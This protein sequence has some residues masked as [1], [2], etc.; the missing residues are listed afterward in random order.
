MTLLARLVALPW[1][2]K[3]AIVCAI[4]L[5]GF[6]AAYSYQVNRAERAER[7]AQQAQAE[8]RAAENREKATSET[9]LSN[10]AITARKKER[11]DA[12][13]A[14]PDGV[15]DERELRRRCRQLRDAGRDLPACRDLA[16]S[17]Q[18]RSLG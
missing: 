7:E 17:G 2:I 12:A 11:D 18:A 3:L 6:W 10:R 4:S 16:G 1:Q 5:L 13:Q 8:V 9:I 14:L 15:P